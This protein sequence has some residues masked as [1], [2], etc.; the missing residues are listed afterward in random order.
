M[1]NKKVDADSI[2]NRT[3]R[4]ALLAHRAR[5][6]LKAREE[7]GIRNQ[8]MILKAQEIISIRVHR[9]NEDKK[10]IVASGKKLSKTQLIKI[11][12]S[13]KTKTTA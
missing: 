9:S 13:N 1:A 8:D 10:R 2:K 4:S 7:R 5:M 11:I 3:A 6:V 12:N